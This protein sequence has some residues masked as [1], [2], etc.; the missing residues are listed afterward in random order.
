MTDYLTCLA[1]LFFAFW[2][3]YLIVEWWRN[4]R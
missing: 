4:G 2:A 1:L 3:G